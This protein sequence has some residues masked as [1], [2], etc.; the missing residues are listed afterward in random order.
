MG[1]SQAAPEADGVASQKPSDPDPARRG[2]GDA[3]GDRR[4][5]VDP[6]GTAANAEEGFAEP[7]G[8]GRGDDSPREGDLD[9]AREILE[10]FREGG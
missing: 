10:A 7:R 9:R 4:L 6:L 2:G 1:P 3:H 8:L 5:L